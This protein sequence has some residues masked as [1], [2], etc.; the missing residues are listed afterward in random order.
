MKFEMPMVNKAQTA[1]KIGRIID[2]GENYLSIL[3]NSVADNTTDTDKN[4]D[5]NV[6]NQK[7]KYNFYFNYLNKVISEFKN[8][9]ARHSDKI[10]LESQVNLLNNLL[11]E[12][13]FFLRK[14]FPDIIV[15]S[16]I[17]DEFEEIESTSS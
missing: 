4:G 12:I 13:N 5:R 7:A 17:K 6:I 8:V 2:L 10:S 15:N 9:L 1:S 3:T 14:F 11:V 16:L